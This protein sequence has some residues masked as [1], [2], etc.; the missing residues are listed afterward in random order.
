MPDEGSHRRRPSSLFLYGLLACMVS[1]WSFNFIIAK[2]AL[3][4]MPALFVA[5]LRTALAGLL[6]APAFAWD[7]R[8]GHRIASTEIP[9]LLALGILGVALN[10][11]FFVIGLARTSVAHA[12]IMIG[13]SPIL[14]LLLSASLGLERMTAAKL[15]GMILALS[16]VALLQVAPGKTTGASW[17]GDLFIF[18]AALTFAGFTV[19]G[20]Q[21]TRQHGTLTLNTF[22]YV[23]GGLA[24]LPITLYEGSRFPLSDVSPAAW[25]SLLYMAAFSSL[26]AYLIFYY[27]LRFVSASRVAAFAY[28]QPVLATTLA[29]PFLGERP[30]AALLAG[31]A[32]VLTGVL[33]AERS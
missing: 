27:V 30:T 6:I 9:T 19:F 15:A 2:F 21:A 13:L 17:T 5:G 1:L 31:G 24:M 32:L 16:G 28:M 26:L 8:K 29:I 33:V 22:A 11:T 7:Y 25:A 20:K 10:Q 23:G 12:A 18:L 4:E 3:R 14:V